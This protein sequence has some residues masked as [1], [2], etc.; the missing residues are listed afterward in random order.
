[1]RVACIKILK[2]FLY[3]RI[4]IYVEKKLL[5]GGILMGEKR[6]KISTTKDTM[7]HIL[8]NIFK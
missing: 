6:W 3:L 2:I 4:I 8:N 1:M 7:L 5:F